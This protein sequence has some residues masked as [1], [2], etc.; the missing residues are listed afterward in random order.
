[1]TALCRKG[2]SISGIPAWQAAR[3]HSFVTAS[4]F[5]RRET[6]SAKSWTWSPEESSTLNRLEALASIEITIPIRQVLEKTE[7]ILKGA[8]PT[9][10]F[11]WRTIPEVPQGILEILD[12]LASIGMLLVV[13]DASDEATYLPV[14]EAAGYVLRVREPDFDEHRMFRT[15]ERD[16]HLHIFPEGS[17]E[18]Q[19]YLDFRDQLRANEDD[20]KYYEKTK[21]KLSNCE[22]TCQFSHTFPN[23]NHI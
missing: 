21:L 5:I 16:V 20:R 9:E 12:I 2:W 22:G 14:L 10:R 3:T 8:N 1:L 11:A 23:L 18:I 19:R 7:Q 13:K 4:S 15:P 17:R 6:L